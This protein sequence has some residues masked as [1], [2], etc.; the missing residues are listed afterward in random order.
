M[1]KKEFLDYY[2]KRFKGEII[3]GDWKFVIDENEYGY[4]KIIPSLIKKPPIQY[5]EPGVYIAPSWYVALS[6][7]LFGESKP[8]WLLSMGGDRRLKPEGGEVFEKHL[9]ENLEVIKKWY[10]ENNN[11]EVY[12][13]KMERFYEVGL[14]LD[15]AVIPDAFYIACV[16]KGDV[17]LLERERQA[18]ADGSSKRAPIFTLDFFEKC[19][20]IAKEYR[21]GTRICPVDIEPAR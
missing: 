11:P 17:E 3:G 6:R 8:D 9:E 1:N 15:G 4:L 10:K 2:K 13:A 19:V 12:A 7:E 16:I 5:I 21:N 18:R 14:G 20:R